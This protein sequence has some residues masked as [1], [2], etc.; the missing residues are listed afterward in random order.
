MKAIKA[1]YDGRVIV[2][3]E[4]V[5][6]PANTP[7]RVLVPEA[8]DLAVLT[9]GSAKLSEASFSRIWDN[10]EDAAYDNF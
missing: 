5:D 1:R 6:L 2:P 10:D 9:R 8:D 7:V 4:P 3:E